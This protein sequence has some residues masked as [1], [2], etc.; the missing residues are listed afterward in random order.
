M[1][2]QP[3]IKAG[4]IW[5]VPPAGISHIFWLGREVESFGAPPRGSGFG[6]AFCFT[7]VMVSLYDINSRILHLCLKRSLGGVNSGMEKILSF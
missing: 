3:Q 7:V 2:E 5:H 6:F 1:N 4:A